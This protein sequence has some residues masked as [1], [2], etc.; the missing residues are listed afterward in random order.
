MQGPRC[1]QCKPYFFFS[2]ED[3]HLFLQSQSFSL[4]L[5]N[6]GVPSN[7]GFGNHNLVNKALKNNT[8]LQTAKGN[9]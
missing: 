1:C 9:I 7:V 3:Q 4:L 5:E 8:N 6:A 2:I